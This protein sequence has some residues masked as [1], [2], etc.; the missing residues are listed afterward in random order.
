M[1]HWFLEWFF[2][3]IHWYY[4]NCWNWCGTFWTR[5]SFEPSKCCY[6][7]DSRLTCNVRTSIEL[8]ALEIF[9]NWLELEVSY[10][11]IYYLFTSLVV[12]VYVG[13]F[14]FGYFAVKILT[15]HKLWLFQ[16]IFYLCFNNHV[17]YWLSHSFNGFLKWLY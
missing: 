16:C 14:T 12:R 4:K 9:F 8:I 17:I 15:T 13:F 10:M 7:F 1:R 2:L 3:Y 6:S 11:F 5:L